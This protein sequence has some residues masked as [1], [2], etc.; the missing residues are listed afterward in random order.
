MCADVQKVD[1]AKLAQTEFTIIEFDPETFRT[2]L[3]YLHTG[4]C[5]LTCVTIPG[6][7][8]NFLISN[9][10]F[11]GIRFNELAKTESISMQSKANSGNISV[12]TRAGRT[13]M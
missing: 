10:P 11:S 2:L 8:L 3:D 13:N 7:S 6:K 12:W 5:P 1:R 4:S 9:R